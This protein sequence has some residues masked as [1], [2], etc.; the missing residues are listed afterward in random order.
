MNSVTE[1]SFSSGQNHLA[2]PG[3]ELVTHLPS[4]QLALRSDR[5]RA[6]AGN[7]RTK[8]RGGRAQ[9][10]VEIRT[11][12]FQLCSKFVTALSVHKFDKKAQCKLVPGPSAR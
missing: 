7:K 12:A 9:T 11:A 8:R 2:P 6:A 4:H 5:S 3:F 10:G 1:S